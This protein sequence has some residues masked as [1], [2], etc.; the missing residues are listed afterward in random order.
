M[1]LARGGSPDDGW[2]A[3]AAHPSAPRDRGADKGACWPCPTEDDLPTEVGEDDL[4]P[5][6]LATHESST[7]CSDDDGGASDAPEDEPE[8]RAAAIARR[9]AQRAPTPAGPLGKKEQQAQRGPEPQ[10]LGLPPQPPPSAKAVAPGRAESGPSPPVP[11]GA[12]AW[13]IGSAGHDAGKCEPCAWFWKPQGCLWGAECRRCHACPSGELLSRRRAKE[14]RLRADRGSA[15]SRPEAAA[16]E[17][18][19]VASA[20]APP[21]VPAPPGLEAPQGARR[22]EASEGSAGHRRGECEPCAWFWRPGGCTRG[23][24]CLRCHLCPDGTIRAIRRAKKELRRGG[25]GADAPE[26]AAA[27]PG[28]GQPAP[29]EP[30]GAERQ[31]AA[32]A[33]AAPPE[34]PATARGPP[35]PTATG[36]VLVEAFAP[37]A[38]PGLPTPPASGHQGVSQAAGPRRPEA[39]EGSAGHWRGECEP[40]AWFWRPGGCS[41]AEACRRCHLCPDGAIQARRRAKKELRRGGGGVDDR[42]PAVEHS[43]LLQGFRPP[44]GLP[45][46][47]SARPV[48]L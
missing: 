34:Q 46:P 21:S 29:R 2:D 35:A 4:L 16:L 24:A 36:A 41:H 48:A 7:W 5:A 9:A 1:A 45:A 22:A 28:S 38:P 37:S 25:G 19:A 31:P 32:G 20:R 44:P 12:A 14:A 11:P 13:S 23:E 42:E 6:R 15:A 3:L 27:V 43:C 26:R 18:V 17:E 33:A 47:G 10:P 8:G 40:C 30:P 39:S